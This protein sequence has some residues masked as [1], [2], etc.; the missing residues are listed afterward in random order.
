MHARQPA[1][2]M[3]FLLG[4][5]RA[6]LRSAVSHALVSSAV[7]Y[8]C[9]SSNVGA[10]KIAHTAVCGIFTDC[11]ETPPL[12]PPPFPHPFAFSPLST[13]FCCPHPLRSMTQAWSTQLK[14]CIGVASRGSNMTPMSAANVKSRHTASILGMMGA[15]ARHALMLP[16]ALEAPS[17]YRMITTGTPD[18]TQTQLSAAPT[19]LHAGVLPVSV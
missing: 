19:P 11:A 1:H 12:P 7:L 3:Q 18:L 2:H 6:V 5:T 10:F 9:K 17:L 4:K 15:N 16:T 8:P 14:L 13:P